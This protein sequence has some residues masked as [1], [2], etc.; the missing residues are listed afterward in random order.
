MRRAIV[1][2]GFDS[3]GNATVIEQLRRNVRTSTI[4]QE[5]AT[6][7]SGQVR[8]IGW[9]VNSPITGKGAVVYMGAAA[10]IPDDMVATLVIEYSADATTL[11]DG[12]WTPVPHTPV[13]APG[14]GSQLSRGQYVFILPVAVDRPMVRV[15]LTKDATTTARNPRFGLFQRPEEGVPDDIILMCGPSLISNNGALAYAGEVPNVIAGRDAFVIQRGITNHRGRK[16]LHESFGESFGPC[17][18]SGR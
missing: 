1:A 6:S 13:P 12:T 17:F 15:T 4:L 2:Q 3:A 5:V 18:R 16:M 9:Q 7:G 11:T 10:S 8:T 14:S